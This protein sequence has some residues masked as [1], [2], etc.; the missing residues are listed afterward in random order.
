MTVELTRQAAEDFKNVHGFYPMAGGDGSDDAGAGAGAGGEGGG[1]GAGGD[2]KVEVPNSGSQV[3]GKEGAGAGAAAPEFVTLIP[4]EYAD[5]PWVKETKDLPALFK[6]TDDL[7]TEVGK[8]SGSVNIPGENA[9]PDEIANFNKAF[10]VPE[11]ADDYKLSDPPPELGPKDEKFQNGVKQIFHKNGISARQALGLEKDWNAMLG[12]M[13]KDKG[14]AAVQQDVDFDKL[15]GEVFGNRADDAIK[16]ANSL[17]AKFVPE[18]MK[19][20]VASLSNENLIILAG[21]IDGIRKEYINEDHMPQGGGAPAG[22]TEADK[23]AE[24]LKLQGSE[25]YQNPF[26][27]DHAEAVKKVQALYGTGAK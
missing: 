12:Q 3:P 16:G 2:G 25:A 23:R 11:K 7:L 4:K 5:K 20:H 21:V 19:S 1:A 17:I 6:R 26:H 10:G 27:P 18:K 9:K 14:L 8:R 13:L 15:K 24:G 22:M